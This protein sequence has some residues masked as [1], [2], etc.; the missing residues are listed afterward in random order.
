MEVEN[1]VK[2]TLEALGVPVERCQWSN[3]NKASAFIVFESLSVSD[4]EFADDESI[5]EEYAFRAELFAKGNYDTLRHE[6]KR[7]LKER[8]FN[9]VAL[10]AEF[11]EPETGYYH[12]SISFKYTLHL[13]EEP[14][15]TTE[16]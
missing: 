7:L 4:I 10:G 16:E 12:A 13:E 5:A 1:L 15:E 11:Y 8:G 14:D 2:V 6:A 3:L 9:R